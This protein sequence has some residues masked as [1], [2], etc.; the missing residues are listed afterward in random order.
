MAI[1]S[2]KSGDSPVKSDS[3][4]FSGPLTRRDFVKYSAG[5]VACIYLGTL[6]TGCGGNSSSIRRS[7]H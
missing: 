1:D 4:T 5:T 2:N 3:I 7:C 6:T